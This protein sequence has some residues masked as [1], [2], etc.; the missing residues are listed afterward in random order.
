MRIAIERV[1]QT[2]GVTTADKES[3][4]ALD[5]LVAALRLEGVNGCERVAES[6]EA[7]ASLGGVSIHIVQGI[8]KE[9][10]LARVAQ[11]AA[12]FVDDVVEIA[13]AVNRRVADQ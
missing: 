3:G 5:R 6:V 10:D 13:A 7:L 9:Q 8:G 2:K 4:G 11:D 12:H 1:Q